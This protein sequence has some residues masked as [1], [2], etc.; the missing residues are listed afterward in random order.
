MTAIDPGRTVLADMN[1]IATDIFDRW[2]EDMRSG[3]LLAALAGRIE[4]YD[5]RVT[6]IRA[7]LAA[8]PDLITALK[9]AV[10]CLAVGDPERE[11]PQ[12]A[13]ALRSARAALAKAETPTGHGIAVEIERGA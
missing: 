5:P 12:V 8:A 2:D 10:D 9:Q 7:V 1:A 3:K 4:N 13:V 11:H 6:R